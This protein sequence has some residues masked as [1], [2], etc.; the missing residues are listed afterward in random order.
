MITIFLS[1]L[2]PTLAAP[3]PIADLDAAVAGANGRWDVLDAANAAAD[4]Y[5]EGTI[6]PIDPNEM[7]LWKG[8]GRWLAWKSVV[9]AHPIWAGLGASQHQVD[10]WD[11]EEKKAQRL[12]HPKGDPKRALGLLQMWDSYGGSG[13]VEKEIE[14]FLQNYDG[15]PVAFEQLYNNFQGSLP[16]WAAQRPWL[17]EVGHPILQTSVISTPQGAKLQYRQSGFSLYDSQP[18]ANKD[19]VWP[20]PVVLKYRDNNG[21][22]EQRVILTNSSGEVALSSKGPV[23]WLYPNGTGYGWYR[24]KV[25]DLES[26]R[27]G[28]SQLSSSEQV[29]LA[30]NQW[31]LVRS[32]NALVGTFFDIVA[33]TDSNPDLGL[34]DIFLVELGTIN[35]Y[36]KPADRPAYFQFIAQSQR[37][38][39]DHYG[40]TIAADEDP[41]LR[42]HKG[43][44]LRWMVRAADPKAVTL[45]QEWGK[46]FLQ[47]ETAPADLHILSG[48]PE[49]Y[50][51]LRSDIEKSLVESAK[52]GP[53]LY[54]VTE[55]VD[56]ADVAELE[57]RMLG[58]S[59]ELSSEEKFSAVRLLNYFG[60]YQDRLWA[61]AQADPAGF[62]AGKDGL[63][64]LLDSAYRPE[65]EVLIHSGRLDPAWST[66][67]VELS[68]RGP[69][70]TL[71]NLSDQ[72]HQWLQTRSDRKS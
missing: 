9:R 4:R 48:N 12:L 57:E 13:S 17:E 71:R 37:A 53:S 1:L 49:V 46:R 45:A 6:K 64:L 61:R 67:L 15:R 16:T 20:I 25:E 62:P 29:A 2:L 65:L 72:V 31:R 32:G 14:R 18:L 42:V 51:Q 33:A 40:W 36:V 59:S 34:N 30:C 66:H 55:W 10:L 56:P 28:A 24:T 41:V 35:A 69:E 21:I 3:L 58:P 26:L 50:Q 54:Q 8:V 52:P 43:I 7:A 38:F 44:A 60:P 5:I 47:G 11:D 23:Q 63:A 68:E 27:N 70:W 19:V 39:L 22:Q